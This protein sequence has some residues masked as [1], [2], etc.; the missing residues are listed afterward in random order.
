MNNQPHLAA[1]A[2]PELKAPR[3]LSYLNSVLT[4]IAVML[5][6]LVLAQYG[7]PS[8][9]QS[10]VTTLTAAGGEP[11]D[12]DGPGSDGRVS[13][14][15]QRKT[16]IA[17]L[18]TMSRKLDQVGEMLNKGLSVKV[19]QMPDIKWPQQGKDKE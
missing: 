12:D 13:A 2:Q 10:G 3:G 8:A 6:L 1:A 9:A 11:G 5:G 4:A 18:R 15:E 17:E 19:T 14:A 7:T 16:M